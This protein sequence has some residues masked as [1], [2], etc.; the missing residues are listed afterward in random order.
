VG[1]ALRERR[2]NNARPARLRGCPHALRQKFLGV[3]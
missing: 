2:A 1:A 3:R